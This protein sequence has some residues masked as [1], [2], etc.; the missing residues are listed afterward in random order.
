MGKIYGLII[1]ITILVSCGRMSQ[2]SLS[3]YEKMK[4][5][6]FERLLSE[7]E[8]PTD[9]IDTLYT[10]MYIALQVSPDDSSARNIVI[11][12][13]NE[14]LKLDT[15]PSNQRHYLDALAIVYSLNKDYDKFLSTS[16]KMWDTYPIESLERLSSYAMYHTLI[17]KE[18]DSITMYCDKVFKYGND[19]IKSINPKMRESGY[20]AIG[21]ILIAKGNKDKAREFF[22]KSLDSESDSEN[23]QLLQDILNNYDA[24]EK[25]LLAPMD[26]LLKK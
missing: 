10:E 3:P 16:F 14:L 20:I 24:Y 4:A 18:V 2:E 19:S 11:E 9:K 12:K 22:A 6:D 5:E 8:Q 1:V 23:I 26:K 17:S 13:V 15:I 25:S 7:L 21:S